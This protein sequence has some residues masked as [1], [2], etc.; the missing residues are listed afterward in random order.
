M[1]SHHLRYV[2]VTCCS[3]ALVACVTG[4]EEE[5]SETAGVTSAAL[6]NGATCDPEN[7]AGV[8]SQVER[9]LLDTI[10]FAE[11]TRDHG[12]DGYNVTFAYR[13]FDSCD[14]HPN[15]KICSGS[16]CSTAAGR[17]Q[18]LYKTYLGLKLPN[19]WPEQQERGALE[20]IE[21]R[22]VSLPATPLTATQFAN[23]LDKLSYEWSSLPPGRYGETRR[24]LQQIRDEY[25]TLA[26]CGKQAG[27]ER[28]ASL[29]RGHDGNGFYAIDWQGILHRYERQ[30]SGSFL[31]RVL[32]SGWQSVT[33]MG[34]GADYDLDGE[35]DFVTMDF[36]YGLE[37]QLG[38]G[39]DDFW[40][41]PIALRGE[42]L[43]SFG[44]A[45]DYDHDAL[46]D[47]VAIDAAGYLSLARGD[48]TGRFDIMPLFGATADIDSLGGGAD[49][50]GD[51]HADFVAL[52][53]NGSTT[54]YR[55][56][57]SGHFS[58]QPLQLDGPRL[59][60]LGGGA[61]YTRDG[62]ADL[63][64]FTTDGEAYLYAGQDNGGFEA[65]ALGAGWDE[66]LFVD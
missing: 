7:A 43:I 12:K 25:C 17:Y 26:A 63:L 23:A 36:E 50:D 38:D 54:L 11:G 47:F 56:D 29:N 42:P 3:L 45:A 52:R 64:A 60:L 9:A 35:P 34:A 5:S 48:G 57:G 46:P 41:S 55:G 61:D 49:Y 32:T 4:V 30:A 15:L 33:S 28:V 40:Y 2:Y 21:R 20:L 65:R 13:Y 53:V 44:A 66:L 39:A 6:V 10:A 1:F 27:S 19:F 8:A 31:D 58:T 51:G 22:G 16:L 14:E 62:R 37:L 24:T 18:F 59:R